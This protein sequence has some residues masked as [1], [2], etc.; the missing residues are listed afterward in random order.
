LRRGCRW[1]RK[2]F[3]ALGGGHGGQ[4]LRLKQIFFFQRQPVL[5]QLFFQRSFDA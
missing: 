2:W 4:L 1:R 3:E 5:A